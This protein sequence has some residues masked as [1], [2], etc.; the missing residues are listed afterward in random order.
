M[1]EEFVTKSILRY[2]MDNGWTVICYDF[3]QSGTGRVLHPNGQ[4][5]KTQGAIVPDIVA[6]RGDV[7]L[8]MENKDRY[9]LPDYDK[10]HSALETGRYSEGFQS[11]L[12]GHDIDRIIGGIGMP[13]EKYVGDA[14]SNAM[15]VDVVMCV[16]DGG[17][18]EVMKGCREFIC[19]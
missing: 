3:P 10:V 15:L 16:D 9:Y 4:N 18:V 1:R 7:A 13:R 19:K 17:S 5:S 14:V 12:Q 8:Y 2:L 11:I 6:V